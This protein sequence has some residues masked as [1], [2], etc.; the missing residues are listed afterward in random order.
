MDTK[1]SIE[2]KIKASIYCMNKL[3]DFV[4]SNDYKEIVDY[5]QQKYNDLEV[6]TVGCDIVYLM[7]NFRPHR[8]WDTIEIRVGDSIAFRKY[9]N[10]TRRKL[11]EFTILDNRFDLLTI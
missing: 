8:I 2:D 5:Y 11:P 10:E 1:E 3:L 7:Y 9:N 6:N 4:R